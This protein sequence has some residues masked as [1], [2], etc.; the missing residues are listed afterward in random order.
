MES[1]EGA[2]RFAAGGGTSLCTLTLQTFY[3]TIS[4]VGF[5][6]LSAN[7][8][9][10]PVLPGRMRWDTVSLRVAGGLLA[11]AGLLK[12]ISAFS[13]VHYLAEPDVVIS[14]LSNRIVLVA[15]GQTELLFSVALL[16]VPQRWY[17]RWGLV[18]L[19]AS[20]A[21]YRFGLYFLGAG[22][23][24]PCLGRASD[25]LRLTPQQ[26]DWVA[27]ALL[28]VLGSI[29]LSSLLNHSELGW[30]HD[31]DASGAAYTG[32]REP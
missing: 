23:P 15:A 27:L 8:S 5:V 19:C 26:A 24:C 6:N 13:G 7:D 18:A 10:H 14:F 21:V 2:K 31:A 16:L 1:T 4:R 22:T 17:A 11:A 32:R 3:E 29:G 12:T 9:E 20:F 25:W 30:S 28:I